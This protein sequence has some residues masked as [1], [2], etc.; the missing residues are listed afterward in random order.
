MLL[1]PYTYPKWNIPPQESRSICNNFS[2]RIRRLAGFQKIYIHALPL[3][4][5]AD[6]YPLVTHDPNML[7]KVTGELSWEN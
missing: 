6:S 4:F 1:K 7:K 3:N 2:Q 5:G